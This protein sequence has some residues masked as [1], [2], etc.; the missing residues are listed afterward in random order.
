MLFLHDLKNLI[1]SVEKK[2]KIIRYNNN[3]NHYDKSGLIP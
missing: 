2:K 1:K 3:P